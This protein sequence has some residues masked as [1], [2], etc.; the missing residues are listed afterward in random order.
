MIESFKISA[1]FPGLRTCCTQAWEPARQKPIG[2]RWRVLCLQRL[3]CA[4]LAGWTEGEAASVQARGQG[5]V[6]T[7]HLSSLA[8][9]QPLLHHPP[10]MGE[11]ALLPLALLRFYKSFCY[12]LPNG[13]LRQ[14]QVVVGG[15]ERKHKIQRKPNNSQKFCVKKNKGDFAGQLILPNQICLLLGKDSFA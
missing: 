15:G 12:F 7:M 11:N 8:A 1:M 5:T 4:G 13:A 3:C 9:C 6:C 2:V 14:F 10:S